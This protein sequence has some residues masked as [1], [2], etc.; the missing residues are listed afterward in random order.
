VVRTTHNRIPLEIDSTGW[1]PKSYR[2]SKMTFTVCGRA[3]S[4]WK[5]VV[6]QCPAACGCCWFVMVP[7]KKIGP[8]LL[9][10]HHTVHFA[11][12]S[13]V[14]TTLCGFS[15]VQNLVFCSF[16]NQAKRKWASSLNH[17]QLKVAFYVARHLVQCV[18]FTRLQTPHISAYN[19]ATYYFSH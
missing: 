10:T 6:S 7:S 4:F 19:D 2:T 11:A 1:V 5:N 17:R 13:D 9:I 18:L 14:S 15:D 16:T 12:W 8:C 3:S